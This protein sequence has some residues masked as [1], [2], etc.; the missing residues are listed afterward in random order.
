MTNYKDKLGGLADKLKTTSL[1]API[2]KVQ[3]VKAPAPDRAT[4][5]QFNN[6]IPKTLLKRL[7]TFCIEH[8]Q[9]LK[10]C[11]IEALELLLATKTKNT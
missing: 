6:W 1:Q 7:K 4:E 3:P 9:S 8:E 5:V 11:N 2:Q 10:A